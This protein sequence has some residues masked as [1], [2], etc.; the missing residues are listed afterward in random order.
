[1]NDQ[2]SDERNLA[3]VPAGIKPYAFLG[4]KALH[5]RIVEEFV[6][7]LEYTLLKA[8]PEPFKLDAVKA[9]LADLKSIGDNGPAEKR[10]RIEFQLSHEL[11]LWQ[12]H[13]AARDEKIEAYHIRRY[14]DGLKK[15]LESNVFV[16]LCRFYRDLPHNRQT[17][18]K[19]D[20]AVTRAFS[21]QENEIT[22]LLT[23]TREELSVRMAAY[24][25]R[26]DK[27]PVSEKATER[28][29][30]VLDRF[31]EESRSF[32]ELSK[33]T[34]SGIFDRIREFKSELGERF[35]EPEL[36]AAA[37]EC[38]VTV[39]NVLNQLMAKASSGLG[40]RLGSEFDFAGAF[41]DPR[42]SASNY[43]TEVL[44][45]IDNEGSLN[46]SNFESDDLRFL[47]SLLDLAGKSAS[48]HSAVEDGDAELVKAGS[49]STSRPE[50]KN[51]LSQIDR[52]NPDIRELN[53][54]IA[55]SESLRTLDLGDFLFSS[56]ERPDPI[57]RN[58]LKTILSIEEIRANELREK[59]ELNSDVR[60]ELLCLLSRAE[61]LGGELE[62]HFHDLTANFNGRLLVAANKLLESRL[63]AE[64]AIVRFS[65]LVA[66]DDGVVIEREVDRFKGESTFSYIDLATVS[67]N[68]WLV[69]ATFVIAVISGILYLSFR[70]TGVSA[71]L[72]D[73]VE[74]IDPIR[75]SGG[76]GITGAHRQGT[77]L[78]AVA[79]DEWR[80]LSSEQK[81]QALNEMVETTAKSK[82]D[83]VVVINDQ[84]EF[85]A[86]L[87]DGEAE[88]STAPKATAAK[89]PN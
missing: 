11:L 13:L 66:E 72:P 16:A 22:R 4:E 41:Q 82:L 15:P 9:G 59:H 3:G 10:K 18:S 89:E 37:V 67:A 86:G 47:R 65:S 71:S 39:G 45:E 5:L 32:V 46:T 88:I 44:H 42:E 50:F 33:I 28:D 29:L 64:R 23:V 62:S 40:E 78:Y 55:Q 80:K 51:L 74:I 24:F 6:T 68:R 60:D 85:L 20:L 27:S 19:F 43:V 73:D 38:N 63:R 83:S 34:E 17:L 77:T 53:R 35:Y 58:A 84:G 8:D 87:K 79:A 76:R 14:C 52:Q 2:R 61:E 69:M 49:I 21:I 70:E 54:H 57:T 75:L 48:G 7:Q 56:D 31:I 26:W 12:D 81:A 36:V 30:R 1:M 25:E